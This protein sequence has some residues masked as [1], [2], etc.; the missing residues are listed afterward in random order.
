MV[1]AKKQKIL[2]KQQNLKQFFKARS[3]ILLVVLTLLI[4]ALT[5]RRA[6]IDLSL[7]SDVIYCR[8]NDIRHLDLDQ[9]DFDNIHHGARE[10]LWFC[11]VVLGTLVGYVI[12]QNKYLR[13]LLIAFI[14]FLMLSIAII[15][16]GEVW[17][18]GFTCLDF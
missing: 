2:P 3:N 1:K 16:F 17:Q 14:V 6:I 11:G 7:N 13:W 15:Q 18:K 4:V 10:V 8:A 5:M 12:Y 9:N